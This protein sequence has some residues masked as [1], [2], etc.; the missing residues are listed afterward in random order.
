MDIL[1]PRAILSLLTLRAS[2]VLHHLRAIIP[3]LRKPANITA[4][5]LP[6]RQAAM[7]EDR[8]RRLMDTLKA[9]DSTRLRRSPHMAV[10]GTLR[11]AQVQDRDQDPT[12]LQARHHQEEVISEPLPLRIPQCHMARRPQCRP[13]DIALVKWPKAIFAEKPTSSAKR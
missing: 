4:L 6:L 11:Q 5:R 7:P 3:L 12:A 10:R 9:P 2:T 1:R 8:Q 13:L